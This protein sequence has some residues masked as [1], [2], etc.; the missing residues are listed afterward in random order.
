[1]TPNRTPAFET[2]P[3]AGDIAHW[4]VENMRH[5]ENIGGDAWWLCRDPHGYC[6]MLAFVDYDTQEFWLLEIGTGE[7]KDLLFVTNGY[8][9]LGCTWWQNPVGMMDGGLC[10][11][12][13][14]IIWLADQVIVHCEYR[15][16][17]DSS[18][19]AE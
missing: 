12:H 18:G 16:A 19:A 3:T 14:G 1:M 13:E 17:A 5:E 9:G 4:F 2:L 7:T 8:D 11:H 15:D 10:W 6:R